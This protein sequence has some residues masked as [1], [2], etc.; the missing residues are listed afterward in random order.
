MAVFN[1]LGS[2]YNF[3]FA[4]ATLLPRFGHHH[5]K[6]K[7]FLEKKYDGEAILFHKGREALELALRIIGAIDKVPLGSGVLINGFTCFALYKAVVNAGYTPVYLDV[8]AGDLNFSPE[9]LRKALGANANIKA[10]GFGYIAAFLSDLAGF[11]RLANMTIGEVELAA[12]GIPSRRRAK[13]SQEERRQPGT[14]PPFRISRP[15]ERRQQRRTR[16]SQP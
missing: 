7:G 8:E 11:Q 10:M 3:R 13:L 4:L 5:L 15:G 14:R 16:A 9:A 12:V 1:S 6:L 2:N